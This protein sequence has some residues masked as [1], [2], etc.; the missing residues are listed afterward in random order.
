MARFGLTKQSRVQG[1]DPGALGT[2]LV[3]SL[4]KKTVISDDSLSGLACRAWIADLDAAVTF[5]EAECLR[6][7]TAHPHAQHHHHHH[8]AVPV[9]PAKPSFFGSAPPPAA[10][11]VAPATFAPSVPQQPTPPI[12]VP[13]TPVSANA[14]ES[15]AAAKEPPSSSSQPFAP[16]AAPSSSQRQTPAPL[17]PSL[18][19]L[20]SQRR[21]S[22]A[23]DVF[24]QED[25]KPFVPELHGERAQQQQGQVQ[26]QGEEE[27]DELEE[28]PEDEDA[29]DEQSS[30][31]SVRFLASLL[32]PQT[33]PT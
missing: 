27:K 25:Q 5:A 16:P 22:G 21:P 1:V 8:A 9:Q 11:P 3:V 17:P 20:A 7:A 29:W 15:A 4:L 6:R 28:P 26:G 23:S 2:V 31:M 30:S 14:S 19:A 32:A 13:P 33:F 18:A 12:Y 24:D 10:Q